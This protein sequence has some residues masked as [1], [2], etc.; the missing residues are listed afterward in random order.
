MSC[1]KDINFHHVTLTCLR[2]KKNKDNFYSSMGA[3]LVLGKFFSAN[4]I[5]ES[6]IS[7]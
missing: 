7:V 5:E 6:K 4:D 1:C 3:K 2:K